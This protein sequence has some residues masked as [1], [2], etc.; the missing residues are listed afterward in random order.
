MGLEGRCLGL[1]STERAGERLEKFEGAVGV[2]DQGVEVALGQGKLVAIEQKVVLA[3]LEQLLVQ[4]VLWRSGARGE[5]VFGLGDHQCLNG[6]LPLLGLFLRALLGSIL[7]QLGAHD[8]VEVGVGLSPPAQRRLG[9]IVGGFGF[10]EKPAERRCCVIGVGALERGSA[11]CQNRKAKGPG[12]TNIGLLEKRLSSLAPG[13]GD[14]GI[15][16][17]SVFRHK[18]VPRVLVHLLQR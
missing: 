5:V 15:L 8:M 2:L 11:C 16:L 10:F 6:Y 4:G 13:L 18:A 3:R 9:R 7:G 17:V 14:G 12:G 1:D